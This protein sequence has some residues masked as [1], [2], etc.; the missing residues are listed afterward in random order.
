[1]PKMSNSYIY[2]ICELQGMSLPLQDGSTQKLRISFSLLAWE[3]LKMR[4]TLC[5]FC[6]FVTIE[7]FGESKVHIVQDFNFIQTN[8]L[9]KIEKNV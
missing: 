7:D 4:I 5:R 9:N 3:L 8:F 6:L 1:M 2:Q